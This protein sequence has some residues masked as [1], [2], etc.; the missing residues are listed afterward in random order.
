MFTTLETSLKTLV[1]GAIAG[2]PVFG[3]FEVIDFTAPG[4][5][6][7][8]VCV[9]WVGFGRKE[10]KDD[11]MRGE[12]RFE[13]AVRVNAIRVD[14]TRRAAMAVGLTTILQRLI[15]WRPSEDTQADNE[16]GLPGFGPGGVWEYPILNTIPKTNIRA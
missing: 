15:A 3:T 8:G 12:Q 13:V 10:Q 1:T 9:T 2:A 11:A 14:A 6:S 16:P 5:P 4:A 7:I